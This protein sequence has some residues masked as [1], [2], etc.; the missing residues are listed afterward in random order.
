[1][2]S[3]MDALPQSVA[4]GRI[5]KTL[6]R[7]LSRPATITAAQILSPRF[8][9]I[10][11]EG[12]ALR[13][14]DWIPGQKIQISISGM[15]V[16]RTYTPMAW[17]AARGA[18]RIL[19]WLHGDGPGSD[20]ARRTAAGDPCLIFGPRRS[21]EV[22]AGPEPLVIVG[23]E[24]AFGLA[25][26]LRE[27]DPGRP[28]HS[29]FETAD[30]AEARVAL[31]SLAIEPDVLAQRTED[32]R[33]LT[34]IAPRLTPLADS[35]AIFVLAG[36]APAIQHASREL[37]AQGIGTARMRTKAYWAPGKTGLD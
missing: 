21:I 35:G 8:R 20:W 2:T 33:H 5:E 26:A 15:R 31:E 12:E 28:M 36:R 24:T 11:L 14:I 37:K 16:A 29:L 18:A 23:D 6:L 3:S 17:D 13:E 1:M 34:E 32:D 22:P 30:A 7:W 9:L 19:V 4:P 27:Q 25:A 10:E